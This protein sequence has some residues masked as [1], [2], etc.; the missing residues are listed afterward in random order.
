M[1]DVGLQVNSSDDHKNRKI[2]AHIHYTIGGWQIAIG[3]LDAENEEN[4]GVGTVTG[5]LGFAKV[6]A[7][8]GR[9]ENIDENVDA[10]K[11]RVFGEIPIGMAT[12]LVLWG[13]DEDKSTKGDGGSFGVNVEH[14]LGGG[15][16][17]VA[18]YGEN[19]SDDSAQASAGIFFKF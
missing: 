5:D 6:G 1:G 15:V 14:S 9:N 10:D 17:A 3:G 19:A 12:E 18:G 2:S 8:F 13:A 4:I 16:T 7:A 11:F